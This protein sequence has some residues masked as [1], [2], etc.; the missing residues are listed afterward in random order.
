M[1]YTDGDEMISKIS[2][3]TQICGLIGDPVEHSLSP[4]MHNAA[5]K[6]TGLNLFTCRLK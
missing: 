1:K 3:S 2:A 5:F 6:K 4:A